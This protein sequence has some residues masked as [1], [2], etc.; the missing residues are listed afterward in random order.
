MYKLL[1]QLEEMGLVKK[2]A[3]EKKMKFWA[4]NPSA[5]KNIVEKEVTSALIK[6]KRLD[7]NMSTLV[8]DFVVNNK[9][10][11]IKFYQGEKG[12][13]SVLKDQIEDGCDV[14]YIRSLS[15]AIDIDEHELHIL[16]N[17][18]VDKGIQRYGITQD[19]EPRFK[20]APQDR[21]PIQESDKLMNLHRTW[22]SESDYDAPV[23]WA[24][25][26]NKLSII[27]FGDE[28]VAVVIESPQIAASFRQIYQLLSSSIR[29]KPGYKI[30][31]EKTLYTRLPESAK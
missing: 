8:D 1:E 27:S 30:L 9:Q 7:A 13:M 20:V 19:H 22:I 16:R 21:M 5:L 25:Y 6:S 11:H 17:Q 3:S 29:Q 26:G 28:T 24:S 18:Y 14:H 23:E 15:D 2:D 31:P 12:V 4:Q 10:P